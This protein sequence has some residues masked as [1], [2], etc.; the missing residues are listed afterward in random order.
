[1]RALSSSA[2]AKCKAS[3]LVFACSDGGCAVEGNAGRAA[4]GMCELGSNGAAKGEPMTASA[5]RAA[6]AAAKVVRFRLLAGSGLLAGSALRGGA[7]AGRAGSAS[8][9][10]GSFGKG[11]GSAEGGRTGSGKTPR[12]NGAGDTGTEPGAGGGQ[13]AK[14]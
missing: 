2:F 10:S 13:V 14:M 6:A 5:I 9:G 12:G 7:G 3:E 1:M 8:F 4:S 11:S